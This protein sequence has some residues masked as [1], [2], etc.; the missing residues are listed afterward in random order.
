MTLC[1]L[2][3]E[4]AR[5]SLADKTDPPLVPFSLA[6]RQGQREGSYHPM[7]TDSD[8]DGGVSDGD[9]PD[10]SGGPRPALIAPRPSLG[11]ASV[12]GSGGSSGKK[13][14]FDELEDIVFSNPK[15]FIALCKEIAACVLVSPAFLH[16]EL[17][18]LTRPLLAGRAT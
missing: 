5:P 10:Y 2:L 3:A 13:R 6:A 18:L 11:S 1:E 15:S 14:S 8:S 17:P 9:P 12:G 4:H 7:A 16:P